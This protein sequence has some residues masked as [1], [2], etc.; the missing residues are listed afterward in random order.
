MCIVQSVVE[1][2]KRE[3]FLSIPRRVRNRIHHTRDRKGAIGEE[4]DSASEAIDLKHDKGF[5]G[6]L[7]DRCRSQLSRGQKEIMS[8]KLQGVEY[9]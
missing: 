5:C 8:M 1:G 2:V 6:A 4:G 9:E 7:K 3:I